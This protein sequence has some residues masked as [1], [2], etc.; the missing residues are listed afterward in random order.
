[1]PLVTRDV[2]PPAT[3]AVVSVGAIKGGIR[4]NIIPAE[5]EM[6]GTIRTFSDAQRAGIIDNM[7][8][9]I[10][11]TAA[12]NGAPP[13]FPRA[14]RPPPVTYNDPALTRRILPSLQQ[15]AGAA[16]V[17]EIDVIT[18]AEDFA[19]FAR[20]VPGVYFFIGVTPPD[21]DSASAPSNHSDYF[22]LD[23]RGIPIGL[24]AMTQVVVD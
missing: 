12:A 10:E 16:H 8:R 21:Q 24:R 14:P 7:K 11:H 3:P 6:I 15:V 22:Y 1:Q 17:K 4:N 18:A 2:A 20:A 23:E 5:V 19:F 13:E 9:I